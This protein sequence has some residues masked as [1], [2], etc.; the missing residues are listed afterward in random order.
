MVTAL[1]KLLLL[2]KFGQSPHLLAE[3]FNGLMKWLA[4]SQDCS[5]DDGS[6]AGYSLNKRMVDFLS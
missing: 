1:I 3:S 5:D 2:N 4:F 6:S